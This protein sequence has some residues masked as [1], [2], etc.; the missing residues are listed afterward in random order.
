[1]GRVDESDGVALL[2]DGERAAQRVHRQS[3]NE[4]SGLRVYGA[5]LRD[6]V[7]KER[8]D[9]SCHRHGC[10]WKR[11]NVGEA[12][13]VA[14]RQRMP[15]AAT[16]ADA[17]R[18]DRFDVE[19]GMA[20]RQEVGNISDGNVAR[21]SSTS[22]RACAHDRRIGHRDQGIST[23]GVRAPSARRSRLERRRPTPSGCPIRVPAPAGFR[24]AHPRRSEG[25]PAAVD[26]DPAED[27]RRR[28]LRTPV[29][30]LDAQPFST[31]ASVRDRT[32]CE[33]PMA[34]AAR[35]KLPWA[36]SA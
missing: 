26:D 17:A 31:W 8:P 16:E 1:M 28:A 22:F 11:E 20:S 14:R 36:A 33:M 7:W 35:L 25:R 29:E 34:S 13:L 30:Q 4:I 21:P 2:N 9:L 27:R 12:H 23:T 6:I 19:I 10:E 24:A 18:R 5:S 3:G 32:G 15:E